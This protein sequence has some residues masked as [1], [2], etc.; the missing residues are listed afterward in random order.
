V[1]ASA[2]SPISDTVPTA[3]EATTIKGR[4]R[5]EKKGRFAQV[6]R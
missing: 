4:N 1:S 2:Q 5:V 6:G 3:N